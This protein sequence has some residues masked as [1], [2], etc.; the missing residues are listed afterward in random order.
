MAT[1]LE[2]PISTYIGTKLYANHPSPVKLRSECWARRHPN[3]RN[4]TVLAGFEHRPLSS[5]RGRFDFVAKLR[6]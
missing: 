4:A 5:A 6:L 2:F 1:Y 3:T